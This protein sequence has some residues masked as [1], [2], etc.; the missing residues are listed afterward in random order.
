MLESLPVLIELIVVAA[1]MVHWAVR[2][3]RNEVKLALKQNSESDRAYTDSKVQQL[4]IHL[5]KIESMEEQINTIHTTLLTLLS[6]CSPTQ[7]RKP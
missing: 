1:P 7:F 2:A 3:V 6:D 4:V 5:E